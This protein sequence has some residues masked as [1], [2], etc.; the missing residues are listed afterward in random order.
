VGFGPLSGLN[1]IFE[2]LMWNVALFASRRK[3][4]VLLVEG[5]K[6]RSFTA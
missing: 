3:G 1:L 2:Y 4:L 6:D 5:L